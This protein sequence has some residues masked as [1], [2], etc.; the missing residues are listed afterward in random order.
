MFTAAVFAIAK[1]CPWTDGWINKAGHIHK[2]EHHSALERISDT[3][4]N[5]DEP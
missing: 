3:C 4:Y 5:L 2:I 1:R